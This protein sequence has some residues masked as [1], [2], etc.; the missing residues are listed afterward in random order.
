MIN[1]SRLPSLYSLYIIKFINNLNQLATMDTPVTLRSLSFRPLRANCYLY[2]LTGILAIIMICWAIFSQRYGLIIIW[3]PYV[4]ISLLRI[5]KYTFTSDAL[6]VESVLRQKIVK[7]IPYVAIERVEPI[8][9]K[10]GKLRKLCIYYTYGQPTW[11]TIT[12]EIDL[13]AFLQELMKR[14]PEVDCDKR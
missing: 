11:I 8:T 3:I 1:L 2:L 4:L 10:N 7:T 13:S 12:T 9:R 5:H 14:V 6:L